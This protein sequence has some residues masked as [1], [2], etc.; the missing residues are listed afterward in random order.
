MKPIKNILGSKTLLWL[1]MLYS[2]AAT[3]LFFIPTKDIPSIGFSGLDKIV[4][5]CIFFALIFLWLLF[6]YKR[7]NNSLSKKS[8]FRVFVLILVY[9]IV[10]EVFQ[11]ILT[12]SRTADPM[13]VVADLLGAGIGVWAFNKTKYLFKA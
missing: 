1:A 12:A 13:D 6:F 10:V 5:I 9:G 2:I 8:I 11:E 3:S 7:G 4:H